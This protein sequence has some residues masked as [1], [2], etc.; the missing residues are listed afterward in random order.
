MVELRHTS[1]ELQCQKKELSIK[2]N[3][4]TW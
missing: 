3:E 2:F 4:V 1:K